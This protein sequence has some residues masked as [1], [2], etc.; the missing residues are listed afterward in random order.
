MKNYISI[1]LIFL[2]SINFTFAQPKLKGT[3][4]MPQIEE[5]GIDDSVNDFGKKAYLSRLSMAK[6]FPKI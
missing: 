5:V 6:Q 3:P 2:C 1:I 4:L